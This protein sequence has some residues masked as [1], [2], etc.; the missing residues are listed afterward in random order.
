[1]KIAHIDDRQEELDCLCEILSRKLN[2]A[3]DTI[4]KIY[5]FHS[6]EEFLASWKAGRFDL[7]ILDVFMG[8]IDGISVAREIRKT[9]RDVRLVFCSSSNE[10]A[11]ESYAVRAQFYLHKPYSEAQIDEMLSRLE[12][13]NYELRRAVTLPDGQRIL[14]RNVLFTE[15][16]NHLLVLH[17]KYGGD[18]R[19]RFSQSEAETLLCEYPYFLVC[20]KGI[21]VNLH[22]VE[23]QTGDT[24]RLTNGGTVPISRRRFKEVQAAFSDFRFEKMRREVTF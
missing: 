7:I 21:I 15:Y 18:I 10:F 23:S 24:F 20:S 14:L 1:M 12:L 16:S 17:C 4:H 22:E 5:P 11:A 19:C 8:E 9:D 2:E 6:G 3:G 13:E